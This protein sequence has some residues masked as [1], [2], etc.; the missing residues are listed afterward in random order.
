MKS[1]IKHFIRYNS[2]SSKWTRFVPTTGTYPEGFKVAS[3]HC[4]IKK[5]NSQDLA[6][7]VSEKPAN[8]AAVFTTNQFQAAPVHIS[9]KNL[10][11]SEGKIQAVIIN[12]GCANAITG[13]QGLKDAQ[14]MTDEVDS[15][16]GNNKASTLVMSTGVIGQL[17]PIDKITAGIKKIFG[18]LDASH[19]SWLRYAKGI[20][21]TDTFPKLVSRKFTIGG[22]SYSVAGVSKGAGMIS[23][24]MATLLGA[25]VTDA[26]V[27]S[28]ALKSILQYSVNRSYNCVSV[29]GDM[30]TNDT[31][32]ALA[33]GEG[34]PI[35]EESPEFEVI[36]Q[37]FSEVA[38]DLAKLLV[39]DG[40]G[41][42]KFVTLNVNNC[43]S[44]EMAHKIAA[45][46]SNSPL[47]K[48]ALF[49]KDANWGRILAA[50][51]YTDFG[52][53][54]K[55]DLTKISLSF[56]PTDG[57]ETLKLLVNGEPQ[58]VNEERASEILEAE[59]LEIVVDIGLGNESCQ[60]WTCDLSHD[61]V[62]INGDYRS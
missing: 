27:S 31:I 17:L 52:A 53:P 33:N 11:V 6:L 36:K 30:S 13:E 39:R 55:L 32:A 41:A 26:P 20:M 22:K 14:T 46:I 58:L 28:S 19:D 44:Y 62:T 24:N 1:C 42:T 34:A 3:I 5:N 45:T 48:T 10:Q 43:T 37:E 7:L 12:S 56:V 54:T 16:L 49:G 57:S 18:E 21:T 47:V 35:T 23:P 50:I 25:I 9:R 8:A 59:D 60:Y 4:G 29:D 51:G 2:T 15:I 38:K 40:E 61:Y